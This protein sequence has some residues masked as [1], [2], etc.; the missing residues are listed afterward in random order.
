L[1]P[2]HVYH[3]YFAVTLGHR[4]RNYILVIQDF[5]ERVVHTGWDAIS[6]FKN[7]PFSADI[8][9]LQRALLLSGSGN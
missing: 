7:Q 1:S 6:H 2:P 4:V 8:A 3:E 9:L 5:D